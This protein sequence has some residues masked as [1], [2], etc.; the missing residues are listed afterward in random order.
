MPNSLVFDYNLT[1]DETRTKAGLNSR[2]TFSGQQSAV[3]GNFTLALNTKT[4]E[5]FTLH[6]RAN[7]SIIDKVSPIVTTLTYQLAQEGPVNSSNGDPDLTQSLYPVLRSQ[8]VHSNFSQ[9]YL[10]QNCGDDNVCTPNLQITSKFVNI[11]GRNSNAFVIGSIS[12]IVVVVSVKN[13]K[14][15]AYNARVVVTFPR[16]L[17]LLSP[18]SCDN[19]REDKSKVICYL[20]NPLGTNETRYLEIRMSVSGLTVAT[21]SFQVELEAV[22]DN[23]EK[24]TLYDNTWVSPPIITTGEADFELSDG[25][26]VPDRI[27]FN[28]SSPVVDVS[29][30]PKDEYQIGPQVT[31][32][33]NVLNNGPSPVS[34]AELFILWPLLLDQDKNDSYLLYLI[35]VTAPNSVACD[36]RTYKDPLGILRIGTDAEYRKRR[37]QR[38]SRNLS[39]DTTPEAIVAECKNN[40]QI[41]IHCRLQSF[42]NE[43][44]ADITVISRLYERTLVKKSIKELNISSTAVH[45][46]PETDNLKIIGGNLNYKRLHLALATQI[47]EPSE[48]SDELIETWVIVVAIIGTALFDIALIVMLCLLGFFK[49]TE[50]GLLEKEEEELSTDGEE[51]LIINADNADDAFGEIADT[52]C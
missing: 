14:E 46:I 29:V 34:Q 5:N 18:L 7:N 40:T 50:K 23:T 3:K 30:S 31:H 22:S 35:D 6:L 24:L 38:I 20:G 47:T 49:R 12:E 51:L 16:E 42:A 27:G 36:M 21:K 52:H 8:S 17:T 28:P 19:E 9:T 39:P 4:C 1:V 10:L 43:A 32:S 45:R 33:F 2:A 41:C 15:N 44:G 25:K 13:A 11:S 37:S 48:V 26:A